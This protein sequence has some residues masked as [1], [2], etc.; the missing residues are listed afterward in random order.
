[1]KQFLLFILTLAVFLSAQAA[2]STNQA[3]I[4]ALSEGQNRFRTQINIK[5]LRKLVAGMRTYHGRLNEKSLA[6]LVDYTLNSKLKRSFLIDFKSCDVIAHEHVIHGGTI[7]SPI[8]QRMGD[9]NGDGIL[10]KCINNKGTTKYM[11]RPG[12]AV[13]QGCHSTNYEWPE[14][15]GRCKA[16]KLIGL[17]KDNV[18][19]FA[20][21][22]VVL[23]E[24]PSIDPFNNVKL[25]GQ[26][27]PAYAPGK[28]RDMVQKGLGGGVLVYV[29]APQCES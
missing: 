15:S 19:E 14:I 10:D 4:K 3:C 20:P 28:L 6:L 5:A 12:F 8:L 22:G 29:Y 17:Q 16:I 26:G 21:A 2:P 27:C 9:L 25:E 11:T 23:H 24:H 13:T 7:Y 1:M 18:K